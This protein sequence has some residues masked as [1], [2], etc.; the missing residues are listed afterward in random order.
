[1]FCHLYF[2]Q[3]RVNDYNLLIQFKE[4]LS[5]A[6]SLA[7]IQTI[8]QTWY[9]GTPPSTA[10]YNPSYEEYLSNLPLL[11]DELID[12]T[13]WSVNTALFNTYTSFE[14]GPQIEV[15]SNGNPLGILLQDQFAFYVWDE[16]GNLAEKYVVS[17]NP[18]SVDSGGNSNFGPTLINASS[19]Y[20]YFFISDSPTDAQ[21]TILYSTGQF[22]L[23][24][25]DP[26]S[27]SLS[28]LDGEIAEQWF[29]NFINTE[30]IHIDLLLDPDYDTTLKQTLDY[31]AGQIRKDCLALL[32]VPA[33]RMFNVATG[34]IIAQPY[35][36]MKLYVA[37]GD[38]LGSLNINS[39]YSAIYGQYFKVYDN[40]NNVFRWVP[41]TGYVG[42][43]IATID[44]NQA[45]WWAPA[46]LNR[47]IISGI[48]AIAIN[49][50]QAQRDIMY[51]NG[52]NP[53]VQFSGQGIVIWGQKTL[54]G[55]P[56]DFDRIN[57]RRLFL[58][59]ERSISAM[60]RFMLFEF[61]DNFTRARFSSIV[62]KF[63]STVEAKEVFMT[64]R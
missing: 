5:Q 58:Y 35:T 4:Q 50:N 18:T 37:G 47:G 30:T 2:V 17:N 53:I 28:L 48:S 25:A 64:S 10:Q 34:N 59:L 1:M 6:V 63:L 29:A 22:N 31:I 54:T 32:N 56:S 43:T 16:L 20:V 8:A 45:Q 21:G 15:D 7:D 60:A 57:V 33:N 49:P 19:A 24:G 26:L 27:T 55:T 13:D 36:E 62:N 38:P 51:S 61:N 39:T 11:R 3:L 23:P 42:A 46:G 44:F 52:I 12:P 9:T 41:T 14:F 40:Y